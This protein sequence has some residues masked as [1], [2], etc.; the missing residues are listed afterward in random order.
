MDT[1][2]NIEQWLANGAVMSLG[3][4]RL[5]LGWGKQR[6]F[7]SA[8]EANQKVSFY[9]PDFFLQDQYPWFQYE[10][11]E[12]I[13]IDVLLKLLSAR[14]A[15]LNHCSAA[16]TW[17]NDYYPLFCRTFNDLK[18]QITAHELEKAVPFVFEAS[19][20][21]MSAF[22][23]VHSL[24]NVL[25]YVQ[26]YP[27]YL[28]GFWN[29]TD[30][31]LGV[32]PEILFQYQEGHQLQT[33]ACAGTCGK[34]ADHQ[35]FLLDPKQAN[36][37]HLVVKGIEEVLTTFGAVHIGER[38]LLSLPNINHL[39]TPIT[40][41]LIRS[42]DF[43]KIVKALHPTPALGA[44]P[45][46]SGMRW[47]KSYQQQINRRRFGAPAAFL[48]NDGSSACFVAIRNVQWDQKGM[49]VGAG[50]GIVS[51]SQCDNEWAEINL[52]LKATKMMLEL[53]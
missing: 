21:S 37:H 31:M 34:G 13:E 35:Q 29:Q 18:R 33:M 10:H 47:L 50:C 25:K 11:T 5:L 7:A 30:G 27:V 41:D 17:T 45:R 26:G 46:S 40:V 44:F 3:P 53:L 39:V 51:D 20:V 28:Y 9:F 32:T 49:L 48:K 19:S 4:G 23:L 12:E 15:V 42:P 36:E 1:E 14:K 52:K 22:Q 16:Y 43:D 8:M 6:Q 24:C 38:R 2:I